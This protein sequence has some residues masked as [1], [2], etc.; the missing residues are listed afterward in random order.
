MKQTTLEDLYYGNINPNK[1]SFMSGLE[2]GKCFDEVTEL[3]K[4][5]C[6]QLPEEY[7]NKMNELKSA[8]TRILSE[9]E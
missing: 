4:S 5:V 3:S 9:T 6:S 7:I 2:Y 8:C 1:I